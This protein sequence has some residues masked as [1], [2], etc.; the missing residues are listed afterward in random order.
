MEIIAKKD[1]TI[2]FPM[3]LIK[4]VIGAADNI[5]EIHAHHEEAKPSKRSSRD[6]TGALEKDNKA[7]KEA[8][9]EDN[10]STSSTFNA[11]EE[12]KRNL[13]MYEEKILALQK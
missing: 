11:E 6:D 9:E 7:D 1:Q 10:A 13:R 2:Q 4:E 5:Y 8:L 12:L 3:D